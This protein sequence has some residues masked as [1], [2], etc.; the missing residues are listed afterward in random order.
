MK[1]F[2]DFVAGSYAKISE[3]ITSKHTMKNRIP[4]I[5]TTILAATTACHAV[6]LFPDFNGTDPGFGTAPSDLDW[7]TDIWTADATGVAAPSA[8][9]DGSDAVIDQKISRIVN[10]GGASANSLTMSNQAAVVKIRSALTLTGAGVNLTTDSNIQLEN[11]GNLSGNITID[12]NGG[13]LIYHSAGFTSGTTIDYNNLLS[14]KLN[15]STNVNEF[16]GGTHIMRGQLF[17]FNTAKDFSTA[18]PNVFSGNGSFGDS[19]TAANDDRFAYMA[20][21]FAPGADGSSGIGSFTGDLSTDGGKTGTFFLQ[22]NNM[23][24]IHRDAGGVLTQDM[25]DLT[26]GNIEFGGSLTVSLLG[27]SEALQEDDSFNLFNGT[28]SGAFDSVILPDLA[29]DLAWDNKL[30]V[31]GTITVVAVPEPSSISLVGLFGMAYIFRRR[32]TA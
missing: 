6:D 4:I 17:E 18:A 8:W 7:A 24:D 21:T 16:E 28:F 29:D 9:I 11:T 30:D 13:S 1:L 20:V 23:F 27:G 25:L 32:K 19:S 26:L 2:C 12:A 5:L 3:T 31:D 15:N 22:G 10:T 14:M